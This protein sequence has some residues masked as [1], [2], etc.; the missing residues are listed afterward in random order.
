MFCAERREAGSC[1]G[2]RR[3]RSTKPGHVR[4]FDRQH[5]RHRRPG[6]SSES[7]LDQRLDPAGLHL[8]SSDRDLRRQR[9]RQRSTAVSF[10]ALSVRRRT[11]CRRRLPDQVGRCL[12]HQA[13]TGHR[14]RRRDGVRDW[15]SVSW[16]CRHHARRSSGRH[17]L[18]G[19]TAFLFRYSTVMSVIHRL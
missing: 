11:V 1:S 7:L 19:Q 9:R 13:T 14:P 8:P 10:R 5:R 15:T 3:D 17:R 6:A 4:A 18:Q 12:E 16:K 2:S